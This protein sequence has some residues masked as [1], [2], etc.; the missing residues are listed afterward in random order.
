MLEEQ[1]F[2]YVV[3]RDFGFAP[4]PFHGV[5]TLATCKPRIRKHAELG[6][7]IVGLGGSANQAVG[8]CIFTMQVSEVSTFD[9]YWHDHRFLAKRPVRN[10]SRVMLLGDNIYHRDSQGRWMQADSHHSHSDGTP[11]HHNLEHDTRVDRVLISRNFVYWGQS[12]TRLPAAVLEEAG[13]TKNPRDYLR[14]SLQRVPRLADW[15]RNAVNVS[16]NSILGDPF[17]FDKSARRYN[18][19]VD[20][21]I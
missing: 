19:D 7:W 11:N 6:D 4:N 8:R 12:A 16:P 21:L 10:G 1:V 13:A 2:L 3:A 14:R 5:C 17:Q 15:L 20:R 9:S 18:V